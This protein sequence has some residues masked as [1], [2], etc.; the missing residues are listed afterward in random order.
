MYIMYKQ[1]AVSQL[2]YTSPRQFPDA[3]D[4]RRKLR[5]RR[6]HPLLS[7]PP[8]DISNPRPPPRR[9]HIPLEPPPQFLV[10]IFYLYIY[11][12]MCVYC[13]RFSLA[14]SARGLFSTIA[15]VAVVAVVVAA[16]S[17]HKPS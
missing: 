16:G 14:G 13:I 10:L 17:T 5:R 6:H 15:V 4:I 8:R 9:T 1:R 11:I 12:Y 7:P 2:F 3:N